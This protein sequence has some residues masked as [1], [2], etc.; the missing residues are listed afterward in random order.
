MKNSNYI[1]LSVFLVL[2]SSIAFSQNKPKILSNPPSPL[3]INATRDSICPGQPVTLT[4]SSL[5]VGTTYLWSPGGA[6][7]SSIT[8]SPDTTTTYTVVATLGVTNDTGEAKVVV[9]PLPKPI[10]SGKK[11]ECMCHIDTL[12]VSNSNGPATYIWNNGTTTTTTI[13]DSVCADTVV[14][15]TAYN[16]LGCSHDTTFI[17]TVHT[18]CPS[19]INDIQHSNLFHVFPNPNNGIFTLESS[20]ENGKSSVEIYNLLGE[21][22]FSHKIQSSESGIRINISDQPSGVYFYR[23]LK[24][25]GSLLGEGKLVVE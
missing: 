24:E 4:A 6:T 11:V 3:T 22:V 2:T 15:V 25:D 21:K 5:G 7:T 9:V 19:G 20:V 14:T 18:P 12:T 13:T 1:I 17:I 23:I 10:I 8:V 16:K